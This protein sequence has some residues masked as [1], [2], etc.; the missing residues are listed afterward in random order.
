MTSPYSFV[1][2]FEK[3][4]RSHKPLPYSLGSTQ[5]KNRRVRLPSRYEKY[6]SDFY[7]MV[8][9]CAELIDKLTSLESRIKYTNNLNKIFIIKH[10]GLATNLYIEL[11]QKK[12]VSNG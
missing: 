10:K 12:E 8:R 9:S 6:D 3:G 4:E 2:D 1:V 11:Q 7:D 5:G